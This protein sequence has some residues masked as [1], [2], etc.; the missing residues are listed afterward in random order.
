MFF[1]CLEAPAGALAGS[2]FV[3]LPQE[4]DFYLWLMKY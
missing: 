4:V 1:G 2:P 3:G